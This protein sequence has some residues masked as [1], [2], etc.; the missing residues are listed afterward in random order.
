MK[1]IFMGTPEF[2][3]PT[4][5]KLIEKHM[6]SLIV[7]QPDK[8]NARGNKVT[9]SKVKEVAIEHNIEILQP[10]KI[11]EQ[12]YIE[13]LKKYECDICIVVAFG[14]IL[15]KEILNM[16]KYGC[17]NVHGSLLPKYRGAAPI[18][19]SIINGETK[20]GITTMFMDVGVDTGD[21]LLKSELII[22]D[23]D[24]YGSLYEKLSILGAD[25][26]IETLEKIENGTLIATKQND[27][28]STHAPMITK[29]MRHIDYTKSS[30]DIVNLIRGLNPTPSAVSFYNE[31]PLK[32]LKAEVINNNYNNAKFGEIVDIIKNK[33]FV[34][35]TSDG[36]VLILEVQPQGRKK[37][38]SADYM[39]GHSLTIGN[40]LT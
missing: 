25:L 7:T 38:L 8:P 13:Q 11:R 24:T 19:W 14:Q 39:R 15:P 10:I 29:E 33:G 22:D 40:I 16:F 20:T 18:Q 34:V 28:E 9:Y 5:K 27:D 32:I 35:K 6:V 30:T 26:L 4:L 37:M 23:S 17:I 2:A 12:Q 1:V 3:V 21:M 31:E 36:A